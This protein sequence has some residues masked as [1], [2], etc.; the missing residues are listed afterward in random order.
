MP[1]RAWAPERVLIRV[2]GLVQATGVGI[3]LDVGADVGTSVG[4]GEGV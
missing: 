4:S 1:D 3:G 2:S